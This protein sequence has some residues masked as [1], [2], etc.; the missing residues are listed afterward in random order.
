[1]NV[2]INNSKK[3]EQDFPTV[4]LHEYWTL[5]KVQNKVQTS[6]TALMRSRGVHEEKKYDEQG[7]ITWFD[8][9]QDDKE[10]VELSE[11]WAFL[12]SICYHCFDS[13]TVCEAIDKAI[14]DNYK[15]VERANEVIGKDIIHQ[16][17]LVD[18]IYRRA[19]ACGINPLQNL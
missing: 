17:R 2:K 15:T 13:F 4:A 3:I 11:L 16:F 14:V 8:I 18:D 1:M 19:E 5:A 10:I 7:P 6:F 12:S 9:P